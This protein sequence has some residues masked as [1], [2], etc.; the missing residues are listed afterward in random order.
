VFRLLLLAG[1]LGILTVALANNVM[2]G[3]GHI[4]AF[5]IYSLARGFTIAAGCVVL[6]RP[7]GIEGAGLSLLMAGAVDVVFLI[8]TLRRLHI[9]PAAIFCAAY[10]RPILLGGGIGGLAI[11]ARPLATS[12]LGLGLVLGWLGLCYVGVGYW[13]GVFGETEK[14]AVVGFWQMVK[15]ATSRA[16]QQVR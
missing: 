12:W 6:I 8:V 16:D 1:Y 2:I 13:I 5:T 14:R 3:M 7:L 10:L 9:S 4:R 15:K 11:L